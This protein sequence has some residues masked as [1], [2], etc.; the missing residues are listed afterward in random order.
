MGLD[1]NRVVLELGTVLR[2]NWYDLLVRVDDLG[3][4]GGANDNEHM[5]RFS[6]QED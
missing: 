2:T 4:F 1:E 5:V 6:F 3:V